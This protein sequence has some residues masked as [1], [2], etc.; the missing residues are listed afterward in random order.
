MLIGARY[1]PSTILPTVGALSFDA[2]VY[3]DKKIES[4]FDAVFGSLPTFGKTLFEIQKEKLELGKR[5]FEKGTLPFETRGTARVTSLVPFTKEELLAAPLGAGEEQF[6]REIENTAILL[7]QLEKD[8]VIQKDVPILQKAV[9]KGIITEEQANLKLQDILSKKID[10]KLTP[11]IDD[12][13]KKLKDSKSKRFLSDFAVTVTSGAISGLTVGAVLT[14]ISA[15][16]T[17]V[18]IGTE[19]AGVGMGVYFTAK[20]IPITEKLIAEKR[21]AELGL[22]LGETAGFGVGAAIGSLATSKIGAKIKG[23]N[24]SLAE[25]KLKLKSLKTADVKISI[26]K[27]VTIEKLKAEFKIDKNLEV[28]LKSF[29]DQGFSLRLIKYTINEIDLPKVTANHLQIV[30]RTGRIAK[31]FSLGKVVL[32]EKNKTYSREVHSIT[33]AVLDENIAVA[34]TTGVISKRT[35]KGNLIPLEAVKTLEDIK[36][37]RE[38]IPEEITATLHPEGFKV[39]KIPKKEKITLISD[40]FLG[41]EIGFTKRIGAGKG[42]L[43]PLKKLIEPRIEDLLLSTPKRIKKLG[44]AK[45]ELER[46]L[47]GKIK[48]TYGIK[49]FAGI[50]ITKGLDKV[51]FE[52]GAGIF[53]PEGKPS[54]KSKKIAERR[55]ARAE[56]ERGEAFQKKINDIL[57]LNKEQIAKQQQQT[58]SDIIP[59][60]AFTEL[61]KKATASIFKQISKER[62]KQF[63]RQ[64]TNFSAILFGI[65][66]Y[67]I[68]GKL[69]LT[70]MEKQQQQMVQQQ[71]QQMINL[72]GFQQPTQIQIPK[73]ISKQAPLLGLRQLQMPKQAQMQMQKLRVGFGLTPAPTVAITPTLTIPKIIKGFGFP[74]FKMR[75]FKEKLGVG[76]HTYIK[77]KGRQIRATRKPVSK[78]QA[79]NIGSFITDT[80][81]SRQFS[82]RKTKKKAVRPKINVPPTYWKFSRQK[83]RTYQI[84]KGKKKPLKNTFIERRQYGLDTVGEVRKITAANRLFRLRKKSKRIRNINKSM[85]KIF[86]F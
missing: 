3:G 74:K 49:K 63:I 47:E 62:T 12:A 72:V 38:I 19:V 28:Q 54:I 44:K 71:Q 25:L 65:P 59:I 1:E 81:L 16:G 40:I 23:K 61:T 69:K 7:A 30:D 67:T 34:E 64:G 52:E 58:F 77:T 57:L 33:E 41:K 18:A 48:S 13:N 43:Q 35:K 9:N 56:A 55:I 26:P 51:F 80:S 68:K 36:L 27:H 5:E 79:L 45:V 37:K 53:R 83:F 31:Q 32:K 17:G 2:M 11:L 70:Q 29:I 22:L 60:G 46:T 24:V 42:I 85:N 84:K 20:T 10:A 15:I 6:I 4:F 14:P 8:K 86:G 78:R 66:K 75:P 39:E 73:V 82:I 76:Y 21:Y 50:D